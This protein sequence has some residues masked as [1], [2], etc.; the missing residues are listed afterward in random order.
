MS[1]RAGDL[2][3]GVLL[4]LMRT[5]SLQ[6]DALEEL[7]NHQCGLSGLSGGE[8]DMRELLRRRD[9]GD[10]AAQLAVDVFCTGVRKIIGSYVALL[11]GIDLMIF[12]GGIG[13]NSS[14]VREQ[15]CKGLDCIGLAPLQGVDSKVIVVASDEEIQIARHTRVLLEA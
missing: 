5:E 12:T 2:D 7:L 11:G 13:Q 9:A 3:P 1:T 4:Y 6:V 14:A 10:D 15:I 8:S